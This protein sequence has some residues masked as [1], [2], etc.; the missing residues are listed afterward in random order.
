MEKTQLQ[1]LAVL[2]FAEEHLNLPSLLADRAAFTGA[3]MQM[4]GHRVLTC[5]VVFLCAT[6]AHELYRTRTGAALYGKCG[7]TA[8]QAAVLCW[9]C[10]NGLDF[11]M[12]IPGS[13]DLLRAIGSNAGVSG[14]FIGVYMGAQPLGV[15]LGWFLSYPNW[16][17]GL[18]RNAVL[19]CTV[20]QGACDFLLGLAAQNSIA[21]GAKAAWILIGLRGLGGLCM[22]VSN[23]S[24]WMTIRSSPKNQQ[25]TYSIAK[26]A[27]L[28]LGFILAPVFWPLAVYIVSAQSA[29]VQGQTACDVSAVCMYALALVWCMLAM[30]FSLVLPSEMKEAD[31]S[32]PPLQDRTLSEKSASSAALTDED[33][34]LFSRRQFSAMSAVSATM[35]EEADARHSS[36]QFTAQSAASA[37]TAV[38]AAAPEK[39]SAD[40]CRRATQH[41]L[42]YNFERGFT[43]CAM[44]AG[45]TFLLQVRFKWNVTA[46]GVG[47]AVIGIST[48]LGCILMIACER[49]KLNRIHC[50]KCLTVCSILGTLLLFDYGESPAWQLLL[51]DSIVYACAF[52][53]NGVV[54][55][56]ANRAAMHDARSSLESYQLF[57]V[58]FLGAGRLAGST[59]ARVMISYAGQNAY[60]GAQCLLSMVGCL[61]VFHICSLLDASQTS[62]TEV[63]EVKGEVKDD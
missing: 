23:L 46:V 48:M 42:L 30:L 56:L 59:F 35:I 8:M 37:G 17:H 47:F 43:V 22:G 16:K 58:W 55:G 52:N 38:S 28:Q 39:V 18:I 26:T 25:T 19:V 14:L 62:V 45:T 53:V 2:P 13:Y 10:A 51:A 27:S 33:D 12:L 54:D 61:S 60:A 63:K 4:I 21:I 44:E 57:R 20:M 41:A 24:D 34:E 29:K 49:A 9:F 3:T 6:I 36:R 50:L 5:C 32:I 7:H 1:D 40:E 15:T 11:A 31:D